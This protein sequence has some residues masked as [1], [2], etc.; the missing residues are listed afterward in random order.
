MGVCKYFFIFDKRIRDM[1]SY[2]LLVF[3]FL[4]GVQSNFAIALSD[5]VDRALSDSLSLP[6]VFLIGQ[7][8][9]EFN[10]LT[11]DHTTLLLTACDDNMDLAYDKWLSMLEQMEYFSNQQGFDLKGVKMWINVFWA[12]DGTI[13][14]IAYH[15]KPRSRNVDTRFLTAFLAEFAKSYRFSLVYK[16]K[17]SHYGTANFPVFPRRVEQVEV[18][19]PTKDEPT[20]GGT[21]YKIKRR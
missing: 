3:L 20:P 1:R 11:L 2:R 6:P 14:H 10:Q 5:V 18:E 15:L 13:Q 21:Q 7:H 17:Y 19:P 9:N 16:E 8:E 12:K 4:L